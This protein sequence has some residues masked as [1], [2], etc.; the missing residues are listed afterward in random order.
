MRPPSVRTLFSWSVTQTSVRYLQIELSP[1]SDSQQSVVVVVVPDTDID[2]VIVIVIII[3][4]LARYY[5]LDYR[6]RFCSYVV[7]TTW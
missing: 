2:I 3:F 1:I 4:I 7:R 5:R 6:S